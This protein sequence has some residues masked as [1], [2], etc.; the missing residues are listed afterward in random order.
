VRARGGKDLVD[1]ARAWQWAG[2]VDKILCTLMEHVPKCGLV[3][4]QNEPAREPEPDSSGSGVLIRQ[5]IDMPDELE[6]CEERRL[7]YFGRVATADEGE[8]VART[9]SSDRYEVSCVF[10]DT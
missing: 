2:G 6:Y 1:V 3:P 10:K 5:R 7:L 4:V 8:R 9:G